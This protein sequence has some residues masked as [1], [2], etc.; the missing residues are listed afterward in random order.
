MPLLARKITRS[1]WPKGELESVDINQLSA[2]AITSCLRTSSNTLSTW[3]IEDE[4]KINDVAL[5][6]VTGSDFPDKMDIVVIDKDKLLEQGFII[7]NTPGLTKVDDLKGCHKDLAYL[8][9]ATLGTFATL[10]VE[11]LKYEHVHRFT[12]TNLKKIVRQAIASGRLTLE[13]LSEDIREKIG[14]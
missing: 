7:E 2:D 11:S 14:A 6:L 1:K 3:E 9:Y 12:S 4:S 13:D 10:V 5:A 8:N